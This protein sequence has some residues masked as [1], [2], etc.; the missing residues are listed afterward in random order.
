M[1]QIKICLASNCEVEFF[2]SQNKLRK[3]CS[4]KC[5]WRYYGQKKRAT[6]ESKGLCPQCG[7]KDWNREKNYC[8]KCVRYFHKKYIEK[9][10]N[11]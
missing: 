2:E 8:E 7:N 4:N 11:I 1:V 3:F 6:R 9:K 10:Q 5:K